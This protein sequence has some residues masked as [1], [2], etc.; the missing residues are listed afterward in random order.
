MKIPPPD[1]SP[2]E[3]A[4]QLINEP[5]DPTMYVTDEVC[6]PRPVDTVTAMA[7]VTEDQARAGGCCICPPACAGLDPQPYQ[8]PCDPLCGW[9]MHGCG[10]VPCSCTLIDT[11]ALTR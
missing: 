11:N 7:I 9:C 8:R 2:L 3:Y 4:W 10:Q 5:D 6:M 1:L